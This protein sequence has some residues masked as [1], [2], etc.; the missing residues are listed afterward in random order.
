MKKPRDLFRMLPAMP[1][2]AVAA[3][4]LLSVPFPLT[5]QLILPSSIAIYFLV[6][7]FDAKRFARNASMLLMT[8]GVAALLTL[9]QP[10]SAGA[11]AISKSAG[12]F[13][14]FSV[15]PA[16]SHMFTHLDT[17]PTQAPKHPNLGTLRQK[18]DKLIRLWMAA[19]TQFILSVVMSIGAVWITAPLFRKDGMDKR[20]VQRG[21]S[22]GYAVNVT[23]SPF[24]VIVHTALL[25]GGL[26]YYQYIGGAILIAV[27]YTLIFSIIEL[28][29]GPYGDKSGRE[30]SPRGTAS[31]LLSKP[32]V[33]KRFIIHILALFT[34]STVSSTIFSETSST[35]VVGI[36]AG[37]YF[38]LWSLRQN[39][40]ATWKNLAKTQTQS[41]RNFSGFLP[42][43][44]AASFIGTLLP[45]T[46]LITLIQ[47]IVGVIE[48]FSSFTAIIM[49]MM[50]TVIL[51]LAGIHMLVTIVIAGTIFSPVSLGLNSTGFALLLVVSYVCAMNLSPLVPFT[52]IL[53]QITG[54]KNPIAM[55]SRVTIAWVAIILCTPLLLLTLFPA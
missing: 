39:T 14:L 45:Q 44:I 40:H 51:S 1:F 54:E 12:M 35:I 25:L 16:L 34:L 28:S 31:S 37:I 20:T 24:D 6:A 10:V 7:V 15:I 55:I 50:S 43:L 48:G 19:A 38:C 29:S 46:P 2:Y 33:R 17:P 4:A 26:N 22:L 3:S 23:A 11:E 30:Q 5:F 53:A 9:E 41:I 52:S 32:E 49:I 8:A 36:A 13:V 21:I 27:M 18:P 47:T 42:L